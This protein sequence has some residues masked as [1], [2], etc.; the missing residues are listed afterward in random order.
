MA[1]T[2]SVT[3]I[4]RNLQGEETWRYQGHVLHRESNVIVIEAYYNRPDTPLHGMMLGQGDRFIETYYRDRWYNVF[5]IHDRE[6]D[7]LKGWYC[8]IGYPAE[9]ADD[10]VLNSII[11]SYID[12]ALDLLVYPDGRQLVLDEDE[13]AALP[14]PPDV[15][16]QAR[17]ALAALQV[18]FIA[19]AQ[20]QSRNRP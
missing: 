3:I 12:L 11:V 5:E 14:L 6:D 16:S 13:F 8:N 4:K 19:N 1:S 17:R 15:V 20:G 2:T 18:A 10:N 7:H 9:F